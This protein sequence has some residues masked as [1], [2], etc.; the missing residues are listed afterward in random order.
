MSC[1][2]MSKQDL[3]LFKMDLKRAFSAKFFLLT[4]LFPICIFFDNLSDLI[5]LDK[6]LVSTF[7]FFFQS[8]VFGGVF[9]MYLMNM[10]CVLPYAMC[11]QKEIN[12][13][14][15][16]YNITRVQKEKYLVYKYISG[17]IS[18][19]CLHFLGVFLF[20]LV[21]NTFLSPITTNEFLSMQTFPY[22]SFLTRNNIYG[23]AWIAG[24][25][26]FLQGVLLCSVSMAVSVKTKSTASVFLCPLIT[27]FLLVQIPIALHIPGEYRLILWLN[28]Y[29]ICNNSEIQTMVYTFLVVLVTA[30]LCM[31]YFI[32]QGRRLL[33]K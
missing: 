29:S 33:E 9:S 27:L 28:M 25:F 30:G 7:Y 4:L 19:G 16:L 6:E 14:Y 12:N 5:Y 22:I 23:Y 20:F 11:V 15:A 24:Y 3:N 17:V 8:V 21:G 2:K 32:R 13:R 10:L 18:G 26:A 31:L 1:Y